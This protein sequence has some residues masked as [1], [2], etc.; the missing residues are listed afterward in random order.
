MATFSMNFTPH[1]V[2]IQILLET[3]Y[4]MG[5][6]PLLSKYFSRDSQQNQTNNT[7]REAPNYTPFLP[8]T[9][10]MCTYHQTNLHKAQDF[11]HSQ[12]IPTRH[13]QPH[14]PITAIPKNKLRTKQQHRSN[15]MHARLHAPSWNH[16]Q[17]Y[18]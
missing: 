12:A 18:T 1:K 10:F 15:H 7:T 14:S 17:Q 16:S 5:P 8:T 11:Q 2:N 13:T 3:N 4:H 9:S 6:P